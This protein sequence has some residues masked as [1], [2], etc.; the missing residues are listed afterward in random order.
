MGRVAK[1]KFVDYK[2]SITEALDLVGAAARLPQ[3]GLIIIKPNLTNSSPP[4]VTTNIA[5]AE[6][7]Y[8]YCRT[9]TKAEIAIGEGCGSGRTADV[10]AALGYIALA[11]K[12]GLRLID[13]N[14]AETVLLQNNNAFQL[15]RFYMPVIVRD[16]F[17]IS[18][19]VLKD[20]S[21]TA[22]T[23]AMKNMFGI[24]PGKFYAGSWN[25]SKLHSP[26][27]DKSVVDVCLYKKPDLSVVD[28]SVALKGNHLS[29]RHKNIG[30]ILA[31]F[32]PV[33]VDTVGSETLGHN[34][35]RLEYLRL[36]DG[37]LGSMQNIEII[38]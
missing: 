13:F 11:K 32:D 26:S 1:V 37:L 7:V 19:P 34:P 10:F 5:A 21:F 16:A 25:K 31:G 18:L 2:T 22:T 30:I 15:K 36:A 8:R 3:K 29:G 14:E 20:H 35:N 27:T 24:A 38:T 17:V 12:H 9:Y 4:P 28:A 33:A 23:V 6:A